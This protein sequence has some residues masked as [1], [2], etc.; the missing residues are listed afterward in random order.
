MGKNQ[1][2]ILLLFLAI[3][4]VGWFF[5]SGREGFVDIPKKE[6]AIVAFGD[7]LVEGVGS[8]GGGFVSILS[9]RLETP[10]IN[11]GVSGD[12]TESG[13]K[14]F[15]T[16]V[17]TLKPKIVLLLLGGN[18]GLRKLSPED[19]FARL[20]L[21]IDQVHDQGGAVLLMGIKPA[22]FNQDFNKRFSQLA[23]ES[24]VS[25]VPDILKG[26]V[27]QQEYM[28]D[29]IHPNDNGYGIVADRIEPLLKKMLLK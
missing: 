15:D 18:D 14:R 2:V 16:D 24:G 8:S 21:M 22:I 25:F 19:T 1:I 3:A 29:P 17:L 9:S 27:G 26:L 6:G 20:R 4:G 13:L 23:K 28:S 11:M 10:I 12:T 7:S 5:F